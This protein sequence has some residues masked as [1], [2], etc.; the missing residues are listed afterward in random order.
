MLV[1]EIGSPGSNRGTVAPLPRCYRCCNPDPAILAH[2]M[3]CLTFC[4]LFWRTLIHD[5]IDHDRCVAMVQGQCQARVD[6]LLLSFDDTW[7]SQQ[8]SLGV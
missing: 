6:V 7:R 1:L 8:V 4:L 2:R 5:Q 3:V